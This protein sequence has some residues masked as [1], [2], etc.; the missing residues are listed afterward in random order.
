MNR[1]DDSLYHTGANKEIVQAFLGSE[2]DFIVIGGLAVSWYC[3][4][5][6]ADDMDLLVNPEVE[7]SRKVTD[8]LSL[9]GAMAPQGLTATS[10]SQ[11]GVRAALKQFYYADILT[12]S[13]AGPSF[14]EIMKDSVAAKLFGLPVRLP[15]RACLLRLKESAAA[16]AEG[17]V[18]KHRR[19]IA[20]LKEDAV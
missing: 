18:L 7:N 10:F 9:L 6:Q 13:R 20:L 5:R 19:D 14:E 4:T 15:S 3:S 17:D 12:P 11:L 16:S 2:V 8:A 1:I